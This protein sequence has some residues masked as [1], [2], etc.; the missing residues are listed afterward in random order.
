MK[1]ILIILV[2][3]LGIS[4][5]ANAHT[6]DCVNT[7]TD[8]ISIASTENEEYVESVTATNADGSLSK[9]FSV[10]RRRLPS[11]KYRYFVKFAGEELTVF[12]AREYRCFA[13]QANT[14]WFFSSRSLENDFYSYH[15]AY[16]A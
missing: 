3:I 6:F 9:S 11:G 2:A 15:R 5:S 7:E 8:P 13:I 1:K 14:L 16:N 10:Y 12:W 4:Y